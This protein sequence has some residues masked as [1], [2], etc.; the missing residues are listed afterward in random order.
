MYTVFDW[1]IFVCYILWFFFKLNL[2]LCSFIVLGTLFSIYVL[3]N[4]LRLYLTTDDAQIDLSLTQLIEKHPL[5]YKWALKF[6]V[7]CFGYSCVFV[8]G[9]L[10]YQYTKKTKYLERCGKFGMINGDGMV[11]PSIE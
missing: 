5:E 1:C 6:I 7:N 10:I 4:I 3:S 8:P 9:I 11:F 2:F